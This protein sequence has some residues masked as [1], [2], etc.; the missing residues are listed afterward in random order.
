MSRSKPAD[1]PADASRRGGFTVAEYEKRVWDMARHQIHPTFLFVAAQVAGA[2]RLLDHPVYLLDGGVLRE[3]GV[4]VAGFLGAWACFYSTLL[5][6][7]G[8]KSLAVTFLVPLAVLAALAIWFVFPPTDTMSRGT[9]LFAEL[10]LVAPG[11]AGWILTM[12]RWRAA[13][14]E[15]AGV[16]P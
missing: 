13:R 9:L 15:A 5:R 4:F 3:I 7:A 16:G 12:L 11:V 2:T 8:L 1:A 14:R 6:V 10:S